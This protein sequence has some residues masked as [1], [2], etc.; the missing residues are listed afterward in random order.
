MLPS[1]RSQSADLQN[2]SG[3]WGVCDRKIVLKGVISRKN[4]SSL[5]CHNLK[6]FVMTVKVFMKF[7]MH[8][9]KLEKDFCVD[10]YFTREFLFLQKKFLG[11][12][13]RNAWMTASNTSSSPTLSSSLSDF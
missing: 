9:K 11:S 7:R 6:V 5:F 3:D 4:L 1:Y 13:N 12:L 8:H 10:F 2:K